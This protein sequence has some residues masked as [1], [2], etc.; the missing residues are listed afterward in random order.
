MKNKL[1]VIFRIVFGIILVA[2]AV[3]LGITGYRYNNMRVSLNKIANQLLY[4]EDTSKVIESKVSNLEAELS[5]LLQEDDSM[6]E[7][8]SIRVT[9]CDFAKGT[10]DVLITVVPKEYTDTTEASIYFGTTE[11][12]LALNR[13]A[14]QGVAS[15]PIDISYDGNVTILL[16]D[17]TK[18]STEVIRSYVGFQS[19]AANILSGSTIAMPE[20]A[21]GVLSVADDVMVNLDGNG[22]YEF[23]SLCYVVEADDQILY[24]QDLLEEDAQDLEDESGEAEEIGETEETGETEKDLQENEQNLETVSIEEIALS[25]SHDPVWGVS[26]ECAV[27]AKREVDPGTKIRVLLLACTTEGYRFEYDL[28]NGLLKAEQ[29]E[30]V[31]AA[32]YFVPHFTMYDEKGGRWNIK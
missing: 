14:Y 27:A 9:G 20:Y 13:Y 12:R 24:V 11:Y 3:L 17:G 1:D 8:Y 16:A 5:S 32:D 2:M 31:E 19:I 28:F 30:F 7:D 29:E 15:L 25:Y 10:Y 21:K 18:K 4:L 23:T 6:V 22:L 26:K